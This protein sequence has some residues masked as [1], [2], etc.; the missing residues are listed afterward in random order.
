MAVAFPSA[1]LAR[2]RWLLVAVS[3]VALVLAGCGHSPEAAQAKAPAAEL[4][5][6]AAE[7]LEVQKTAWPQVVR[8]QGNLVADEV[9][10]VGARIAGRVEEVSVDLGDRVS[11]N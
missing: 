3:A 7:V 1:P 4:P 6:L 8:S 10:I 5:T 11:A 9:V 2:S